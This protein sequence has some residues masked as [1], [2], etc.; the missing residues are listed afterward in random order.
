MMKLTGILSA[1]AAVILLIV[2]VLYYLTSRIGITFFLDFVVAGIAIFLIP[3]GTVDYFIS[4]KIKRIEEEIPDFLRDISESL[5]FGMTLADSI[6]SLSG[7][8]YGVLTEDVQ[9]MSARIKWGIPV[10]TVLDDFMA[11]Y[12]TPLIV[13]TF[14]SL[15]K[16]NESGGNMYEVIE[17]I[18][19]HSRGTK[20]LQREKQS[21]LTSYTVI[22]LI[23]YGVFLLTVIILNVQFFPQMMK[24]G[25]A[26][27]TQNSLP[28]INIGV[29]PSIKMIFAGTTVIYG[30]G[31]GLMA[32]ILKDGRIRSGFLIAGILT[33][34]GYITIL[35]IGGV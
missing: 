18:A 13:K 21:Q 17:L 30:V 23:A 34:I 25:G 32:G 7:G 35:L 16:T 24:S 11:K 20:Q 1:L 12:R 8:R 10:D 31:N 27:S 19:E 4:R 15:I 6:V 26:L 14:N 29:I 9:R 33:L 5:R 28:L 22:L 3:V 2:G